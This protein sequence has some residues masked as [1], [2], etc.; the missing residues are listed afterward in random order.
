MLAFDSYSTFMMLLCFHMK[1]LLSRFLQLVHPPPGP[2]A[3]RCIDLC[4]ES[5]ALLLV[6]GVVH[7][8]VPR[9]YKYDLPLKVQRL[10]LRAILSC[11]Y[12]QVKQKDSL[13][14]V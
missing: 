3:H 6:G 1:L 8:P 2:P 11:R 5:F 7:G 14:S 9:S 4:A 12:A 10:G 13:I